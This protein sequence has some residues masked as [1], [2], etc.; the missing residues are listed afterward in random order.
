MV[1]ILPKPA[2]AKKGNSKHCI[3]MLYILSEVVDP[4]VVMVL[5]YAVLKL[6][7]TLWF[8]YTWNHILI[9]LNALTSFEL[10]IGG[11]Y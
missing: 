2:C 1:F 8:I 11:F 6:H 7:N 3:S 10:V 9:A 4:N 5:K